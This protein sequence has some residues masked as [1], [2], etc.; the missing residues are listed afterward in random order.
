MVVTWIRNNSGCAKNAV[1]KGVD[2]IKISLPY[3]LVIQNLD[4]I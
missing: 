3:L 1:I 2:V 4:L